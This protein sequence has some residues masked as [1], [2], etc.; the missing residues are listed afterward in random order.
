MERRLS[1]LQTKIRPV[2]TIENLYKEYGLFKSSKERLLVLLTNKK[3]PKK[4]ALKDININIYDGRS[5][6]IIGGNGS[7]KSTLLKIINGNQLATSGKL[8]IKGSVELLSIKTGISA[9]YTGIENIYYKLT[10]H[11]LSKAQID[12]MVTSIVEFSEL[13]EYIY[14]PVSTYSS[15]MVSKLGFSIAVSL[16]PKILIVDEALSVGDEKF[17]EKCFRKI[18]E[19]KA[20]GTTLLFVSHSQHQ[21]MRVCQDVCWLHNGEMIAQGRAKDVCNLYGEFMNKTISIDLAKSI[22]ENNRKVYMVSENE[23]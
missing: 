22:V 23:R 16:A 8:K 13:E 19:M 3:V 12:D 17:R 11:G 18:D 9:S 2:V 21:V 4:I 5:Y 6:G 10:M 7:G 14:Q 1:K 20:D 15:G